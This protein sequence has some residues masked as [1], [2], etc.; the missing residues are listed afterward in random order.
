MAAAHA[1]E[2]SAM[3]IRHHVRRRH[4]SAEAGE[5]RRAREKGEKPWPCVLAAA[6]AA[7]A[8]VHQDPRQRDGQAGEQDMKA[9]VQAELGAR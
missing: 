1:Y 6:R 9:D 2:H 3:I 8:K 4:L 7:D 5:P